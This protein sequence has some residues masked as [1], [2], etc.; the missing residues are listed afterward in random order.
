MV[1]FI[2]Q[3]AFKEEALSYVLCL[4]LNVDH[5]VTVTQRLFDIH[6]KKFQRSYHVMLCHAKVEVI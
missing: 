1:T 2:R 4:R 6:C 3:D 5:N